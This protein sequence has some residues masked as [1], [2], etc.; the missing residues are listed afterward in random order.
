[1]NITV[2]CGAGFG[3]DVSLKEQV[4]L[5]GKKIA[6]AGDR[7]V[8]GGSETGLMGVLADAVLSEGGSVT[9]VELKYFA[10]KNL[11]HTGLSELLVADTLSGRKQM[12]IDRGD[13]FVALPGGAGTL[14]EISEIITLKNIGILDKPCMR[15]ARFMNW[16]IRQLVYL[17]EDAEDIMKGTRQG[18]ERQ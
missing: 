10:E 5:F 14:D 1:M 15:A 4:E 9:G 18:G 12:M 8:F 7:L 11:S 17:A 13:A 3:N 2:Y 6:Q 16:D